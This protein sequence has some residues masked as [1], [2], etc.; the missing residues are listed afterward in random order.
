MATPIYM[1]RVA[2]HEPGCN[3]LQSVHVL[4]AKRIDVRAADEYALPHS[5]LPG[6]WAQGSVVQT[7]ERIARHA[8]EPGKIHPTG[9]RRPLCALCRNP[10][11]AHPD[12]EG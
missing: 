8:Y 2:V 3:A 5:C 12:P 6:G 9:A 7:V 4:E 1:T 10:Y 11:A